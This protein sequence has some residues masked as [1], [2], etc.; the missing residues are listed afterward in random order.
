VQF[1]QLV[2]V[3]YVLNI[4]TTVC[5]NCLNTK[6]LSNISVVIRAVKA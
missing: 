4:Q 5:R 1:E 2:T 3:H 6:Q